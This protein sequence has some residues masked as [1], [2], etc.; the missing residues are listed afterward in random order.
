MK[1]FFVAILVS[2]GLI[3]A[4]LTPAFAWGNEGHETVG[5]IASLRVK[6][7]TAHRLA[8]ILKP[9]DTLA[10]ISTWADTVK[11]RMG[12]TDQDTDTNAF[13]QDLAHNERNRDWHFVDLPLG[14]ANY[15]TCDGFTPDHD[16]VHMINICIHTL[17]GQADP[18]HPLSE[19]NALRLLAHFIGDL[20]QPLHVGVGFI[21]VNGPNNTILIVRDP[22]A[23]RQRNLPHDRGGNQL[24]IDND[25]KNLHGFWDFD[26]V[27]SLMGVTHRP[28]SGQLG[29]FLK[30]TVAPKPNWQPQ[31]AINTWAAQWATDSLNLSRNQTYRSVR[32]VRQRTIP[33]LRDGQP[34]IRDG[35]PVMQTVY[36]ITR[37]S[38]Y[39]PVNRNNVREQL[40]KAGFRLA[41][42]LD[43]IYAQ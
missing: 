19:R 21:D 23:V 42:L 41:K 17:Q 3:L 35:Q 4:S 12:T 33:V 8:Q 37:P 10:N 34:L 7:H 16:I 25:R 14:C 30:Q 31:G 13:L 5:K 28:T 11:D 22:N 15:Q 40:A 38:N 32:I 2:F 1:K 29:R 18:N 20:H 6:P 9:G 43:A 27:R 24:I 26:L 36:D 39:K